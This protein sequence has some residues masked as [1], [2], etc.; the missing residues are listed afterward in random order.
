[1]KSWKTTLC[2]IL[3][4]VASGIT[5]IAQPMLDADPATL[6]QW[7]AF[8]AVAVTAIGLLFARDNGVTSEQAGVK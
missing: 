1:M 3:G 2:G 8:G 7:T 4:V 6:P 5:M